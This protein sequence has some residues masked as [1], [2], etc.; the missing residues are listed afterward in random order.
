[1]NELHQWQKEA[2]PIFL[3]K[4]KL[5]VEVA[6]GAGKTFFAIKAIIKILKDNPEY[7]V[8]IVTPKIVI[9]NMW[10]SELKKYFTF[11]N[12]GMFFNEIKE[13][14]KITVTTTKSLRNI[15]T[16]IFQIL[17]ADEIHNMTTT[18]MIKELKKN[19]LYK[20]GLSATVKDS[21]TQSH[22]KLLKIFEYNHFEYN[23][24]NAIKDNILNK[25]EFYDI[26]VSINELET[27]NQ[28][29]EV[30]SFI[31]MMLASVGGFDR[32][33]SLP[34]DNLIKMQLNK[35]FD[36][37]KK[38]VLNYHRKFNVIMDILEQ[39]KDK[40]IIVFNEYNEIGQQ[41]YWQC[42]D[43]NI[44]SRVVNSDYAKE[45]K[46][47]NIEDFANGKY[48]VLITSKMFDE[49]YNLPSIDI[50]IIFSGTST[51]RQSIQRIGRVLRLKDH[52][53]KIYQIYVVGTFEAEHAAKRT[54][55]FKDS[56][57]K[58]VEEII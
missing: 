37:R 53:S 20:L 44:K 31:K 11:N 17:V 45:E 27:R 52:N 3:E 57:E 34:A 32:Y 38:L 33:K 50:A 25:F 18:E 5:L 4:K 7:R 6:T 51:D 48:N 9:L 36:K 28:Y 42:L 23:F 1:M 55:I 29:E 16:D 8:L 39:N 49:G 10:V 26:G 22:W 19:Y 24:A 41:I 58:Y 35:A 13:Y 54:N 14:S 30:N 12:I 40:K 46:E 21:N 47:K 2:L 43:V 56:A 15:N